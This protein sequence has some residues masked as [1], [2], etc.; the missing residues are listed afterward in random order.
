MAAS[1]SPLQYIP[2]GKGRIY[3][4]LQWLED[5]Q[6]VAR[7]QRPG[8]SAVIAVLHES[9][10]SIPYTKLS[11]GPESG[12]VPPYRRIQSAW[13][14]NGWIAGL[15]GR[16]ECSGSSSWTNRATN[17]GKA[18]SGCL[19]VKPVTRRNQLLHA[20]ASTPRT[21]ASRAHSRP[22]KDEARSLR[23]ESI[24]NRNLLF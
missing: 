12:G 6:Y 20:S 7:H 17:Q 11:D 10:T 22:A 24:A 19:K 13:W 15:C 2:H 5:H 9:G 3:Q 23:S 18:K 21:Q 16:A 4:A 14:T 1:W 8:K